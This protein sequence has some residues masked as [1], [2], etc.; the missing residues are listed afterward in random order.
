MLACFTLL[1]NVF[2][3]F[4]PP[5]RLR[6]EDIP[7]LVQHFIKRKTKQL[8]LK[9]VPDLAIGAIDTLFNYDW[10]GNVQELENVI[11]RAMILHRG[12]PLRFDDLGLSPIEPVRMT[13]GAP[14][15]ETLELDALVKRHIQRVLKMIG[16]KIHGPGGAGEVL[17]VNPDT[18]R[19]R[20]KKLSIPFRKNQKNH[21]AQGSNGENRQ[22]LTRG[23]HWPHKKC[24]ADHESEGVTKD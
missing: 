6:I 12:N 5:L 7:A 3:L 2:P 18:L 9:N 4:I 10:P 14:K 23:T 20:M 16:G 8:K 1:L 24:A 17:G 19:Y 22:C 11:E 21:Q 15:D 13:V